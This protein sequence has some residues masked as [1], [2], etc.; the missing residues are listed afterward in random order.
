[1]SLLRRVL[2]RGATPKAGSVLADEALPPH[3]SVEELAALAGNHVTN[4]GKQRAAAWGAMC[5]AVEGK[6]GLGLTENTAEETEVE[7]AAIGGDKPRCYTDGGCDG[8]GTGGL[9]GASRWG[10]HV[11]DVPPPAVCPEMWGPVGLAQAPD[12][13]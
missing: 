3:S 7:Q 6:S 2:T 1:M 12:W 5:A 4:E 9:R 8:N 11:L 13:F 10:V